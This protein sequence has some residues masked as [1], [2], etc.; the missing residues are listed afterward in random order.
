[1]IFVIRTVGSSMAVDLSDDNG[2]GDDDDDEKVWMMK[3][4]EDDYYNGVAD[5]DPRGQ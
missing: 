2:D 4:G 5:H 1:M 3:F